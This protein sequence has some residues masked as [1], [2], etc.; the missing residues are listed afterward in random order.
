MKIILFLGYSGSGK[1]HALTSISRA[2]VRARCGKIG[3]VKGIHDRS[4]T[5]DSKGKDT[6]L[7]ACAGASIV[8]ALAPNEIDI[9]R[10]EK[11]TSIVDVREMLGIFKRAR[12]DYLLV[13]GAHKKFEAIR[14]AKRV[15]CARNEQEAKSLIRIHSSKILFVTGEFAIRSKKREIDGIPIISLPRDSGRALNLIGKA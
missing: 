6:W 8:V 13:E 4:F 9:I 2:L 3:T 15:I 14:Q 1:T 12:V 5:I 7:H 11:S 10:K